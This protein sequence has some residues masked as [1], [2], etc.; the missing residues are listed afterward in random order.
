[1]QRRIWELVEKTGRALTPEEVCAAALQL[2]G[3]GAKGA[4][5]SPEK[6]T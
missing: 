5:R 6:G 3:P 1:M 2:L 4:A